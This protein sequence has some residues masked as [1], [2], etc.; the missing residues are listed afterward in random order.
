MCVFLE[1]NLKDPSV[2]LGLLQVG[3]LKTLCKQLHMPAAVVGG[4]KAKMIAGLFK[5]DREHQPLFGASQFMVSVVKRYL[6]KGDG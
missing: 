3:E 6:C 1:S 4:S 5:Q 2:V